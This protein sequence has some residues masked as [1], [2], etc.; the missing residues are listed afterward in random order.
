MKRKVSIYGLCLYRFTVKLERVDNW[1]LA[2]LLCFLSVITAACVYLRVS[3]DVMNDLRSYIYNSKKMHLNLCST[4]ANWAMKPQL[5]EEVTLLATI[6]KHSYY[7]CLQR[8]KSAILITF[9]SFCCLFY[10]VYFRVTWDFFFWNWYL[11]HLTYSHFA[12]LL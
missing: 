6:I 1:I 11:Q 8:G 9:L 5:G 12:W 7:Y 3:T 10:F 4:L 2:S